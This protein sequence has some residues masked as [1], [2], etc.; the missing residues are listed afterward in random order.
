MYTC[1]CSC[2]YFILFDIKVL[3]LT[4]S[5]SR[6]TS[7]VNM[8]SLAPTLSV[9]LSLL[10]ISGSCGAALECSSEGVECDYS[11]TSIIDIMMQVPSVEECRQLCQDE[12]SCH[13]I[14]YFDQDWRLKRTF[15]KFDISQSRRRPLSTLLKEKWLLLTTFTFKTL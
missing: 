7:S 14:T 8:G 5:V 2:H 13:Y 4:G 9:F 11:E 15:A 12:A 6:S 3:T 1:F 10:F